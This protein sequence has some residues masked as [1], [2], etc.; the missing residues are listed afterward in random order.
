VSLQRCTQ[1]V[2]CGGELYE[3]SIF[4]KLFLRQGL[5]RKAFE[6][7]GSTEPALH[8]VCFMLTRPP[9]SPQ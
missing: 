8:V 1:I 9:V 6:R 4:T 7:A 3:D 5:H 2:R